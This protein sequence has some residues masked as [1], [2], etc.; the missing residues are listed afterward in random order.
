M[1]N[2]IDR[3][4]SYGISLIGSPYI[5]WNGEEP[6][7]PKRAPSWVSDENIPAIQEIIKEGVFC[8]GLIN[9]MKR[10]VNSKIPGFGIDEWA[11]GTYSYYNHYAE[12]CETFDINKKYSKGTLLL[13]KI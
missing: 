2:K 3:A 11:G 10:F 8:A 13:R 1:D 6:P 7:L 5:W 12:Y 9:L 4:L